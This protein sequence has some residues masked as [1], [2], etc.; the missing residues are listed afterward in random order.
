MHRRLIAVV[1]GAMEGGSPCVLDV[2]R[3]RGGVRHDYMLQGPGALM[4]SFASSRSPEPK[5][6]L[7]SQKAGFIFLVGEYADYKFAFSDNLALEPNASGTLLSEYTIDPQETCRYT[8]KPN[9]R[10][11]HYTDESKAFIAVGEISGSRP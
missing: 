10:T 3:V 8:V 1:P 11:P 6:C 7:D 4:A 9:C 2:F 5:L